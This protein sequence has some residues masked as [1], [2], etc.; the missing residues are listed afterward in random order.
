MAQLWSCV[1][2]RHSKTGRKEGTKYNE[3]AGGAQAA[4]PHTSHTRPPLVCDFTQ[5]SCKLEGN[6]LN[7]TGRMPNFHRALATNWCRLIKEQRN[8]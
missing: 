2:R 1:D 3:A 8:L 6:I 7:H 5:Q 4:F